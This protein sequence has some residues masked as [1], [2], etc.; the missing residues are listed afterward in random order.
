[1]K[2]EMF[3]WSDGEGNVI[4]VPATDKLKELCGEAEEE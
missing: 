4:L 3:Y 2:E 1:M